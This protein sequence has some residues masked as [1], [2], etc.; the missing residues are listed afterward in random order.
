MV[1]VD[2]HERLNYQLLLVP[3]GKCAV[4]FTRL[5]RR[6]PVIDLRSLFQALGMGWTR[7]EAGA[8]LLAQQ[9]RWELRRAHDAEKRRTRLLLASRVPALLQAIVPVARALHPAAAERTQALAGIWKSH[10]SVKAE[11]TAF[12][13]SVKAYRPPVDTRAAVQPQ[14]P[15]YRLIAKESGVRIT[16]GIE[17]QVL[18]LSALGVSRS[19][20]GRRLGISVA[21]V[22]LLARGKYCFAGQPRGADAAGA[23]VAADRRLEKTDGANH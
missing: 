13:P 7:W 5:G 3:G 8:V 20:I 16:R 15:V 17:E 6:E 2:H 9:Q 22:S 23:S 10:W 21:S 14:K 11:E 1:R 18:A 19:E 4:R 12:P